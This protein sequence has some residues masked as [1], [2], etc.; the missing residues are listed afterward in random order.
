MVRSEK[1]EI[2]SERKIETEDQ[3]TDLEE[4]DLEEKR[5]G[6]GSFLDGQLLLNQ[7]MHRQIQHSLFI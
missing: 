4:E 7:D 3:E 5:A 6:A 1:A 2:E